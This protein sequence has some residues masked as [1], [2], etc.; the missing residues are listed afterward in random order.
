MLLPSPLRTRSPACTQEM[1]RRGSELSPGAAGNCSGLLAKSVTVGSPCPET[2]DALPVLGP[3]W[4]ASSHILPS[5]SCWLGL[6]AG[7]PLGREGSGCPC[8]SLVGSGWENAVW[9]KAGKSKRITLSWGWSKPRCSSR[10]DGSPRAPG[11]GSAYPQVAFGAAERTGNVIRLEGDPQGHVSNH[12][13]NHLSKG[14]SL[15]RVRNSTT[16]TLK[17]GDC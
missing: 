2:K 14:N 8:T 15:I 5:S 3:A 13:S 10:G 6:R 16:D 7:S 11:Y 9:A 12:L 1:T 17:C 4:V